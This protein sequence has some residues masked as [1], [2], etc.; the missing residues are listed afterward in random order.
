MCYVTSVT[1]AICR[2]QCFTHDT[3]IISYFIA[4][5]NVIIHSKCLSTEISHII[6]K[7]LIYNINSEIVNLP[8]LYS[9]LCLCII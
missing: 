7:K 1:V 9:I 6:C 8:I 2:P 5:N 4:F 3:Y